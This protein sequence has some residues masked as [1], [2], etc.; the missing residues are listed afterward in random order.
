MRTFG[1]FDGI[2]KGNGSF[3]ANV[4]YDQNE[5]DADAGSIPGLRVFSS[6]NA[7]LWRASDNNGQWEYR[8]DCAYAFDKTILIVGGR[9]GNVRLTNSSRVRQTGGTGSFLIQS[10]GF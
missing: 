8:I 7:Q 5:D 10:A 1:P 4:V 2:R 9:S 3:T 6:A